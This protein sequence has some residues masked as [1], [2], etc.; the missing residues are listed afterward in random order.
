MPWT[1]PKVV[2]IVGNCVEVWDR[3]DSSK[4]Q[5]RF[6]TMRLETKNKFPSGKRTKVEISWTHCRRP[7]AVA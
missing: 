2:A 1:R 4:L 6:G 3:Q 5:R 7:D